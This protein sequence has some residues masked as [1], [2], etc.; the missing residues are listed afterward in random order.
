M[1]CIA[2]LL[3]LAGVWLYRGNTAIGTT[4]FFIEDARIPDAF[5]GFAIAQLSDLHNTRFG[6]QQQRLIAKLK[7]AAPDIIVVTGDL[8]D[9]R[10]TDVDAAMQAMRQAA[11]IAP[12]Y[13]VTGNHEAR[14]Y[15]GAY[16]TLEAQMEE[17]GV[18]VLHDAPARLYR[19]GET[20]QLIGLDD[21]AFRAVENPYEDM[22]DE[23]RVLRQLDAQDAYTVL[24]SHRPEL[25]KTYCEAGVELAFCGHAHGGQWRIPFSGGVFAPNQGF[26]PRYA[27]GSFTSGSTTMI[28]S[29]GLGRSI[30]PLRIN[31]PPELVI[32]TLIKSG[33]AS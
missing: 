22:Q 11:A 18:H 28:V 8:I 16:K 3:A 31:N 29:R 23:L 25:F 6:K 12:V 7:D 27:A 21:P 24:L 4:R 9:S 19:G 30:V 2:A 26:F 1:L 14:L 17:A 10:H 5:D 32:A 33:E 20:I 15:H 13:Y